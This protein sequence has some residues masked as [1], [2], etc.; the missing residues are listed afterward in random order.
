MK[1]VGTEWSKWIKRIPVYWSERE[2]EIIYIY[3]YIYIYFCTC[4]NPPYFA[5]REYFVSVGIGRILFFSVVLLSSLDEGH[6]FVSHKCWMPLRL[7]YIF[8]LCLY[9]GSVY[10]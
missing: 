7:I 10:S 5:E 1:S 9:L 3:I 8:S 6:S 2:R 4:I